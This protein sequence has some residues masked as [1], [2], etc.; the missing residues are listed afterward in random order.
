MTE[1][2]YSK[3]TMNEKIA[4]ARACQEGQQNKS[5]HDMNPDERW[6]LQFDRTERW[7]E[8]EFQK[9]RAKQAATVTTRRAP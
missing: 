8:E 1:E 6:R 3:L 4:Y 7:R 9:Y 5:L 2:E